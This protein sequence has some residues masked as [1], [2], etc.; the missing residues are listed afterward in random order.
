MEVLKSSQ[1]NKKEK[2]FFFY[3]FLGEGLKKTMRN[4][5]PNVLNFRV[6]MSKMMYILWL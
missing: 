3:E 6:N 1:C 4:N 2:K 5:V